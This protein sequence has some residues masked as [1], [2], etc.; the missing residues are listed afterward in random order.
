MNNASLSQFLPSFIESVL[1]FPILH[2]NHERSRNCCAIAAVI[3]CFPRN[4]AKLITQIVKGGLNDNLLSLLK[5]MTRCLF[6]G[7][8]SSI[9]VTISLHLDLTT[10]KRHLDVNFQCIWKIDQFGC[11]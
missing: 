4:F 1:C 2:L 8:V 10:L 3:N 7:L 5:L 6:N 9:F 11:A